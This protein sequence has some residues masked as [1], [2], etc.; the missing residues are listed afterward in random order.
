MMDKTALQQEISKHGQVGV[1]GD[2]FGQTAAALLGAPNGLD[3]PSA[4]TAQ[5]LLADQTAPKS[6]IV[7]VGEAPQGFGKQV[8]W[9]PGDAGLAV[10]AFINAADPFGVMISGVK[11]TDTIE[12]VSATGLASFAED[13][14]NEGIS[15]LIGIVAAGANIAASAFDAPEAAGLINAGAQFAEEQFKENKVKTKRRDAFG[16]DPG[17]G[18]RARQEGGVL[19]SMPGAGQIFYSGN[20]D[21]RERW[22]K[23]PGI[24]DAAHMPDHVFGAFFLQSGHDRVN[25]DSEGDIIIY[26]WDF[27]FD[28][29]FGFY[30][31]HFLLRRG[32]G[33]SPPIP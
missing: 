16:Q 2:V 6:A 29:N 32:D 14:K 15:S 4:V 17:S 5:F 24:R 12:F 7:T 28:D 18:L 30:R 11:P 19:V 22:I 20:S 23:E 21:H 27:V 1:G 33:V 26:A 25:S 13:T 9:D 10:V 3:K 8:L 31:L